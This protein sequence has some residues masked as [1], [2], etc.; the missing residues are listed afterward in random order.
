M[1]KIDISENQLKIFYLKNKTYVLPIFMILVSMFLVV[2]ILI[3]GI[4]NFIVLREESGRELEK[5]KLLKG[6][7]NTLT[8]L[9]VGLLDNQLKISKQAVPPGKDFASILSAVSITAANAN[10]PLGDF[11]FQV[12]DLIKNPSNLSKFLTLQLLIN[13]NTDL[14]GASRFVK[15][16]ERTLPLSA[17]VSI[18]NSGN[19][20]SISLVFYYKPLPPVNIREDMPF[21]SVSA[22]EASLLTNLSTWNNVQQQTAVQIAVPQASESGTFSNPF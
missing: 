5:L 15:E 2:Y 14:I 21:K 13:I 1:K 11:E 8:Q 17:V 22:Q 9:D 7:L 6:N 20:S 10:V 4:Q 3:P 12:G 19:T 16:I 18:R